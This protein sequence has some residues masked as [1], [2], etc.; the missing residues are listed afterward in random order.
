MPLEAAIGRVLAPY[1]PGGCYMVIDVGVKSQV[2]ALWKSLS[3]ASVQKA[4]NTKRTLYSAHR[5]NK[6]RRK[7]ERND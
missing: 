5:S 4:R 3:E 6:L 2:V 7:V 1:R